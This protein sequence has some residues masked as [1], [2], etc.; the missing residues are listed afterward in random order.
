MPS[1]DHPASLGMNLF[2]LKFPEYLNSKYIYLHLKSDF[3][4]REIKS[5]IKGATNQ[6]IDKKSVRSIWIACPPIEEQDEI[7]LRVEKLFN[8]IE[9]IESS[10]NSSNKY[11]QTLTQSILSKAFRGGL[12]PQDPND[13]PASKLLKRI[14]AERE[15]AREKESKARKARKP[16]Q[17]RKKAIHA[18]DQNRK[19]ESIETPE[20]KEP[21]LVQGR[22]GG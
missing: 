22:K 6:S 1:I 19:P 11:I 14:H 12:V 2:A 20:R 17:K 8:E 5:Y 18:S 13:E 3:S 4:Y 16:Y 15:R 7:V 9:L 10:Y 21:S